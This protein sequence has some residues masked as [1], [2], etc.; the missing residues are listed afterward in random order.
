V[1]LYL[2]RHT[3]VAIERS[4]CYG[5]SDIALADTF[6]TE[7]LEI[8]QK[9]TFNADCIIYSSPLKRSLQ[10][11]KAI[12]PLVRP[13]TDARLMELN[14]GNWEL[15]K[16]T[17]VDKQELDNWMD[18]F[19]NVPCTGGESYNDLYK[20]CVSFF[21]QCIQ[22]PH[23]QVVVVSHGGVIRSILSFVLQIPLLRSFSL[24][25]DYG[26]ISKLK[27]TGN[28]NITVEYINN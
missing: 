26:K 14:F 4:I 2:I 25:L 1:E 6:Q 15:K 8:Q 27:I 23:Q 24:Q 9:L 28:G 12:F 7:L 18:D 10:L 16:W 3:C 17:E 19:V 5:Q 20:R 22:E 21:N 11:A 13:I